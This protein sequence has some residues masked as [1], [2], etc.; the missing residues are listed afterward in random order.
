MNTRIIQL[1]DLHVGDNW[2]EF[3]RKRIEEDNLKKCVEH[4]VRSYRS[5]PKPLILITGDLIHD[6]DPKEYDDAKSIL[7][8]LSDSGFIVWPI[9][10]NHDYGRLGNHAEKKRFKYFKQ[11]F[12]G[13]DNP[14]YPQ[15]NVVYPQVKRLNGHWFIGLNSMKGEL[16]GVER[17]LADGQIGEKQLGDTVGLLEQLSK[18][19]QQEKRKN[20]VI[21]FLHHHPFLFPHD[22][23]FADIYEKFG[24][25][26]EDG[27]KFMTKITG[28]VD[29]L[30]F[31]HDHEHINFSNTPLSRRH[32]IRHILSCGKS[33]KASRE[34]R[35]NKTNM[36]KKPKPV[37]PEGFLA[38]DIQITDRG[39][40]A[41]SS[42]VI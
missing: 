1:S 16:G 25:C 11:A 21:L 7:K 38:W 39:K 17:W 27:K 12:F 3:P 22:G 26:L 34:L 32:K 14:H 13:S 5:G 42:L 4:L 15:E 33:T 36:S 35:V 10:G 18:R 8:P 20:K 40:V 30:L 28:L 24:H 29:I 19:K 23:F 2:L 41:V 31:G 9:P 6:G 37:G